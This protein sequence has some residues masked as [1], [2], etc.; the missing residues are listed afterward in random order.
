[1]LRRTVTLARPCAGGRQLL[2]RRPAPEGLLGAR[3]GP[4]PPCRGFAT[5]AFTVPAKGPSEEQ[6]LFVVGLNS[7]KFFGQDSAEEGLKLLER[8][9]EHNAKYN[10]LVD[11]TTRELSDIETENAVKKG[12][13]TPSRELEGFRNCEFIPILQASMVDGRPRA[14]LGRSLQVDQAAVTTVLWKTP[15][16]ALNLYWAFWQRKNKKDAARR[17]F[18]QQHFPKAAS[19]YFEERAETVAIRA[20]EQMA[21]TYQKGW[22]GTSVLVVSNELY[23]P[24]VQHLRLLLDAKSSERFGSDD[25]V[26]H[27]RERAT[28]LLQEK[29]DATALLV[30]AYLGMPFLLAQFVYLSIEYQIN[31]SGIVDQLLPPEVNRD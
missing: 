8:V 7:G 22:K 30:V 28:V 9:A 11:L 25:F 12:R 10:V 3:V 1:M 18:C 4:P 21:L 24:V 15:R 20:T 29:R 26:N 6:T 27:L 5:T 13:L 14:A 2:A 31:R 16:E 17:K 19:A 23:E